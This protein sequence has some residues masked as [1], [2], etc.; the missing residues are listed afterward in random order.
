MS[1]FGERSAGSDAVWL[2]REAGGAG[3]PFAM[4]S[5]QALRS[6]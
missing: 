3:D 6:A 5:G 1:G 2:T 4:G